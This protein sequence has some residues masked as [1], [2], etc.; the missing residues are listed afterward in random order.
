MNA[1]GSI[2]AVADARNGAVTLLSTS[3]GQ[4]RGIAEETPAAVQQ[5]PFRYPHAAAMAFDGLGRLLVGRRN[6]R[7]DVIDPVSAT[8][9]ASMA[10]PPLSANVAMAVGDSG[11][12]VASGDFALTALEPDVQHVRWSTDLR[13]PFP[14]GCDWL[15]LSEPMQ[16]VYCG[17]R[18]G[19]IGVFDL[20][21]GAPLPAEEIGPVYGSVGTIDVSAD[22][23]VLTAI[24]G[25]RP[26]ISRWHLEGFGI[27]RR[28]VARG[29]MLAGPY[30]FEGSS[31]VTSPQADAGGDPR[32][33]LRWC[34]RG[35]RR[36]GHGDR[37]RDVPVRRA[38]E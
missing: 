33:D 6:D 20:A 34:R 12:V 15:A 8:I 37:R 1:D 7:V 29:H 31:I 26:T 27:G 9:S 17:N 22:G 25:S 21:D 35:C 32:S 11:I 38:G 24:S 28:L 10:V 16:R 30:S 3:D 14:G 18:I 36:R 19:R 2:I 4:T 23:A 5:Q 13:G